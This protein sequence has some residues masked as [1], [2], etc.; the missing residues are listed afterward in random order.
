MPIPKIRVGLLCGGRSAEHRVSLL[1]A[2]NIHS[3]FDKDR[4]SV[5]VI[6][7]SRDGRF[8]YLGEGPD[9]L[10][11]A[12]LPD[13]IALR[14]TGAV[15]LAGAPGFGTQGLLPIDEGRGGGPPLE[16]DLIFPA[17]HGPFGEDGRIQGFFES[18][19]LP[20][21]GAGVLG[22]AV[23]MDK[24]FTKRL[25]REAGIKTAA[26]LAFRSRDEAMGMG[27]A[28]VK[29]RLGG[30]VFVKPASQGSS[31]G[32]SKARDAESF[33][34]AVDEAFAHEDKILVEE[35]VKGREIEC[36]VL[37]DRYPEAS[38]P[39]EIVPL[40]EF[41]DY[42]SK[43][44]DGDASR[45]EIPARLSAPERAAAQNLAVRT[46]RSLGCRDLARVD[47]FLRENGEFLVNEINTLPGFTN[48]SMY[49]KLWEASGLPLPALLDRLA[50]LA[51]GR[52][53]NRA[54]AVA[55]A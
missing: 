18:L 10:V 15:P 42:R 30:T 34:R 33:A 43:Y 45:L 2:R 5:S 19:G 36:A 35:Y 25:L 16:L 29:E 20:V 17:L 51:L 47:F 31:V 37:G 27:Y 40:A 9:F 3:G 22:S 21:V 54:K 26:C 53:E 13:R 24:E 38:L 14:E 6:G 39:G 4:Y 8:A 52:A 12:D 1:S 49:P 48:G 32:V 23:G 46:F 50:Q 44:L 55:N 11:D 7:I 28:A 41:Y